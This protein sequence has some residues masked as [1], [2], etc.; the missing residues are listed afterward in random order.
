[1]KHI[2]T[3]EGFLNEGKIDTFTIM[4]GKHKSG[5][6]V[7][8]IHHWDEERH[9]RDYLDHRNDA[10]TGDNYYEVSRKELDSKIA[11]LKK[12]FHIK[13]KDITRNY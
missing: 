12:E 4:V 13:D 6:M 8:S 2:Q 3:F 5:H 7:M 9:L 10:W 1:M 11:E